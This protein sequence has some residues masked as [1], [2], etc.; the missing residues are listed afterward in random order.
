MH[1]VDDAIM[2]DNCMSH[3]V[4]RDRDRFKIFN[5]GALGW[6]SNDKEIRVHLPC[7]RE[8]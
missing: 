2:Y 3:V 8:N 5:T 6:V 7:E 4:G 1:H